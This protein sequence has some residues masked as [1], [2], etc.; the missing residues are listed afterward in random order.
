MRS[1]P[2]QTMD[3]IYEWTGKGIGWDIYGTTALNPHTCT[4]DANGYHSGTVDKNTASGA[5]ITTSPSRSSS[6]ALLDLS[7][8]ENYSGS[9]YLG[10]YGQ[11]AA[12]APGAQHDRRLLSHV[13][14][15]Q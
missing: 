15:P 11:P 5:P 1:V 4:P 7:F 2:G 6:P 10:M 9:P 8:G 3:L 14:F 12:G 13:A